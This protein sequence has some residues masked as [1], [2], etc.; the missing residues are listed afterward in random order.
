MR[1]VFK[2]DGKYFVY[3]YKLLKGGRIT[4]ARRIAELH[5]ERTQNPPRSI[6]E[7]KMMGEHLWEAEF[8][9]YLLTPCDSK[10]KPE[11]FDW[12]TTPDEAKE[13]YMNLDSKWMDALEFCRSDFFVG[14]RIV[15][16]DALRRL[17]AIMQELRGESSASEVVATSET[18]SGETPSVESDSLTPENSAGA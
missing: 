13:F 11:A 2:Q 18:S 1:K 4:V 9:S 5:F 10:G 17:G 12:N 8:F 14:A 16:P 15:R 6:N 7:L 3:D